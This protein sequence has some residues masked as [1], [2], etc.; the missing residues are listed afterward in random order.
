MN[1][2]K[3]VLNCL[4]HVPARRRRVSPATASRGQTVEPIAE[5]TRIC[6]VSTRLAL[7]AVI[8]SSTACGSASLVLKEP[9]ANQ[10]QGAGLQSCDKLSEGILK[11]V[12][13]DKDAGRDKI[14]AGAAANTGPKLK[15][16]V[17]ALRG[18][19]DFP[20]AGSFKEPIEEIIG[21]LDARAVA[22]TA[23]QGTAASAA[24]PACTP[25]SASENG[26]TRRPAPDGAVGLRFGMSTTEAQAL[27]KEGWALDGND[28]MCPKPPIELGIPSTARA[29][30]DGGRLVVVTI[31]VQPEPAQIREAWQTLKS[32]LESK[33]GPA[34]QQRSVR[35][36]L[37][38]EWTWSEG[39]SI[40]LEAS[41]RDAQ[42]KRITIKYDSPRV[43]LSGL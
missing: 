18:L 1:A 34:T 9:V 10:C 30:F 12:D 27:C 29:H 6:R 5:Q 33:Y 2:K 28:A 26:A 17:E 37:H 24:A 11:Y 35:D 31:E 4:V 21:M 38:F 3:L 39:V 20:G 25:V 43:A 41:A 15:T 22:G 16:F 23:S 36:T 40:V 32:S 7:A 13:G 8:A 19:K 42:A 14:L